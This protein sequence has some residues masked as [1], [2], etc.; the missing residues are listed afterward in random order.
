MSADWS[1]LR[2]ELKV[3]RREGL[4]LPLW[5]RDDDAIASTPALTRLTDLSKHLNV[6]VHLA[7]IP[8]FADDS[9]AQMV[10]D[11]SET[12]IPLVHGWA[13][14]NHAPSGQKKAEFATVDDESLT[15]AEDGLARLQSLFGSKL[16]PCFVPPWNRM[17]M[18]IAPDLAGLGYTWVST[19]GPR[20]G[21]FPARGLE[22][23]NTHIDPI[24]WRG[25]RS[26][27]AP[28]QLVATV[29]Q[30]LQDR[31]HGKTDLPEPLG[32]LTHHLVH[33]VA[34]WD[35]TQAVLSELLEGPTTLFTLPDKDPL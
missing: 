27:V 5:W 11:H 32:L 21:R 12:L 29:V 9:L 4:I 26:A 2:E 14:E 13:H 18:K 6:P 7:V 1:P 30:T 15:R 28:D 34:I 17:D 33:D 19:Y 16:V 23:I 31:R 25:D 10:K 22:Q 8:K 24:N 35:I 3:W 20:N